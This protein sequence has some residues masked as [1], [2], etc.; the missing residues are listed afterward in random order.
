V[1]LKAS[2]NTVFYIATNVMTHEV[3][4][5]YGAKSRSVRKLP[6]KQNDERVLVALHLVVAVVLAVVGHSLGS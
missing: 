3:M 2:I 6:Q 4:I 5:K 1:L